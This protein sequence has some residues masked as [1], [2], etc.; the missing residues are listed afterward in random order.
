M[1]FSFLSATPSLRDVVANRF[2][3]VVGPL[4]FIFGIIYILTSEKQAELLAKRDRHKENNIKIRPY[5][6]IVR[7]IVLSVFMY[8]I[9]LCICYG[10]FVSMALVIVVMLGY[11]SLFIIEPCTVRLSYTEDELFYQTW[12]TKITIP[13][14]RVTRMAWEKLPSTTG[15]SLVIYLDA[16]QKIVLHS[17]YYVGLNNL[18]GYNN[19]N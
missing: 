13:R 18:R 2:F 16:G 8:G 17:E 11:T 14:S 6:I 10:V 12:F 1:L 5:F 19:E 4:F 9:I 7:L 15:Y 3:S